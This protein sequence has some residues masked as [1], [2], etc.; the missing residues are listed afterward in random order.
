MISEVIEVHE[1]IELISY[2]NSMHEHDFEL[3]SLFVSYEN[4]RNVAT[5]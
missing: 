1:V 3:V 4:S 5:L 2:N